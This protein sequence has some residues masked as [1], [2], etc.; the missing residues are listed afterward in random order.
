MTWLASGRREP[1]HRCKLVLHFWL[2]RAGSRLVCSTL[3]SC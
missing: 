3:Q 1:R 2:I